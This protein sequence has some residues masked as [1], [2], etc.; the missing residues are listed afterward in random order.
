M[1]RPRPFSDVASSLVRIIEDLGRRTDERINLLAESQRHTDERQG[2]PA[3]V[4]IGFGS[5]ICGD[6]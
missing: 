2:K 4:L 1:F 6:W 5:E 3:G